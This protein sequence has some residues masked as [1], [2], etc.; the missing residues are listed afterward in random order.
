MPL[1]SMDHDRLL[2]LAKLTQ[3]EA[4]AIQ[5]RYHH[6]ARGHPERRRAAELQSEAAMLR[7]EIKKRKKGMRNG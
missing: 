5:Q 7:R 3:M 2:M 6:S 1:E 4:D